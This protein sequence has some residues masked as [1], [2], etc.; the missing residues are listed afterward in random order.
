MSAP[1]VGGELPSGLP[2]QGGLEPAAGPR[3][4]SRR[5][6][7]S[8][9]DRPDRPDRVFDRGLQHE[10]TALAWERTSI[11]IMVAGTLLARYATQELHWGFAT[12][13]M[14]EVVFGGVLLVWTAQHYE[15][16]HGPLR[17][18]QSPAH[19]DATR[20][21]GKIVI[22]AIGAAVA[23]ALAIVIRG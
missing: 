7:P 9:V 14:L 12:F 8:R 20:L 4:G 18:G 13:G 11:A 6:L 19:P 3:I 21:L 22:G 10:R 17:A 16:L 23:L 5:F 2:L 1:D 15:E